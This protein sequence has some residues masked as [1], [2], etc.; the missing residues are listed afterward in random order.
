MQST[1]LTPTRTRTA[2]DTHSYFQC[3]ICP[4]PHGPDVDHD[5]DNEPIA[6]VPPAGQ[7]ERY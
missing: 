5:E 2:C 6:E 7:D 3:P 1:L 4:Y